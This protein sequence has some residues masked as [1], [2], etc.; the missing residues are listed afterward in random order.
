ML[1]GKATVPKDWR[2]KIRPSR[3]AAL[4]CTALIGLTGCST[5]PRREAVPVVPAPTVPTETEWHEIGRSVEGRP[6]RAAEFG[7]GHN[8]TLI[9][10]G[11][12][13]DEPVSADL[14]LRL[15]EYLKT[16]G[17]GL[18]NALVVI[19]PEVNPD[20]LHRRTRK[21]ANGVDL[22]RNLPASN[23]RNSKRSSATYGGGRPGSEPE[24][25]AVLHALMAY[26]PNKVITIHQARRGP[27]LDY[28]GPAKALATVMSRESHYPVGMFFGN[29]PGSLGSYVGMD[30]GIPIVTLELRKGGTAQSAW[31]QNRSALLAAI[32]F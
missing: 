4:L 5:R 28:N 30:R 8:V 26:R 11:Y 29:L 12:H 7:H 17:H 10:G 2:G 3:F 1:Q 15:G 31:E 16:A 18:S 20:G 9:F 27:M 23:W 14:A 25:K 22:N 6:I 32:E 13:G 19:V 24:T 21:N